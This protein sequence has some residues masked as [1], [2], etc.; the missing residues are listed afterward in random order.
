M[1]DGGNWD[2]LLLVMG[3][4]A[5]AGKGRRVVMMMISMVTLEL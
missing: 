4:W 3:G 5:V 1:A 2:V